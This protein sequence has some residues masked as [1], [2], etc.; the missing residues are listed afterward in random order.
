MKTSQKGI[1]FIK[2]F[3]SLHD[4]DLSQIGLQPKMCPA[5]IWTEGYG[6]AMRDSRGN[7][8]K[9]KQ[10]IDLAYTLATVNTEQEAYRLLLSDLN[11]YEVLVMRLY[12][13]VSLNQNKFDALVSFYFNCGSSETLLKMIKSNTRKD[14]ISEFWTTHYITGGGV[15]LAGLVRRRKEESEMYFS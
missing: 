8:I 6:H 12:S 4:G 7:F 11:T 3:E 15:K 9:G 10:N 2:G 1:D 5:G 13:N 14:I